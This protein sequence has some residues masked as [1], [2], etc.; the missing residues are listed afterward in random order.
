[1]TPSSS[2]ALRPETTAESATT[3]RFIRRPPMK[4]SATPAEEKRVA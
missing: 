1:V 2:H 3:N 4:N